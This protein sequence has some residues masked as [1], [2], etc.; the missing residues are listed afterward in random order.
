MTERCCIIDWLGSS[1][2]HHRQQDVIIDPELHPHPLTT[3][4][5][6]SLL[7]GPLI[8]R[9]LLAAGVVTRGETS[10]LP[11]EAQ[12]LLSGVCLPHLR[13]RLSSF[14]CEWFSPPALSG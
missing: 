2:V 11:R 10:T 4:L 1:N 5:K 3:L 8:A 9:E 7:P 13:L 12:I 14:G 6:V